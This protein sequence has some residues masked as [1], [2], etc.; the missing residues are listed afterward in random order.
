MPDGHVNFPL[1]FRL[2]HAGMEGVFQK[3]RQ[4]HGKLVFRRP[5]AR[6]Q[7]HLLPDTDAR[8]FRPAQIDGQGGIYDWGLAI[9]LQGCPVQ[10]LLP[11]VQQ[12]QRAGASMV[13][14]SVP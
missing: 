7:V 14:R 6:R 1:P 12:G 4:Q 3:I 10:L 2:L 9:A 5:E 8:L 11:L 13:S